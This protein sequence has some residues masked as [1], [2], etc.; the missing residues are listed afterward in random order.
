M[1][2]LESGSV[3]FFDCAF[4][5]P[6]CEA[7]AQNQQRNDTCY[8][9]DVTIITSPKLFQKKNPHLTSPVRK[10]LYLTSPHLT[11]EKKT[12]STLTSPARVVGHACVTCG[13]TR[14]CVKPNRAKIRSVM[15]GGRFLSTSVAA[16]D[17]HVHVTCDRKQASNSK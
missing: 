11:R 7:D 17:M 16:H 8:R 12:T 9:S 4:L 13:C 15:V 5:A 1:V 14:P 3:V 2:A 6:Q 10:K